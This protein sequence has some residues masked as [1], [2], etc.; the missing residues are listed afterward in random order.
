MRIVIGIGNPG[1]KYVNTRHNIGFYILDQFAQKNNIDF[2]PSK[3][4]FWKTESNINAFRFLLIKPTTYVNNT[5]FVVKNLIDN[6][7]LT[8]DNILIIYDDANL[9]LGKIRIRNSGSDGGHNGIKSIIY[10][11]ESENFPRIRIGI[12]KPEYSE[13][14]TDYV[15]SDFIKDEKKIIQEKLPFLY[16]LLT[17]FICEGYDKMLDHFSKNSNINT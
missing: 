9:N 8:L 2:I 3:G 15:L 5:G 12:G 11:L 6:L 16:E 7:N 17:V 4:E 1:K 13:D 10:N 14:M